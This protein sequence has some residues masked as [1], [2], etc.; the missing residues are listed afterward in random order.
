MQREGKSVA[1]TALRGSARV[2][3][4]TMLY[5]VVHKRQEGY[6]RQASDSGPMFRCRRVAQQLLEEVHLAV[7]GDEGCSN[8]RQ[9]LEDCGL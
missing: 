8:G 7:D 4:R 2:K 5:G 1:E 3:A 6:Q 9:A